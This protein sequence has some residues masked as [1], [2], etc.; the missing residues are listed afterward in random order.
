MSLRTIL[1]TAMSSVFALQGVAQSI[2]REVWYDQSGSLR[3]FADTSLFPN[4]PSWS[5]SWTGPL[6]ITPLNAHGEYYG[7]R[8]RGTL[9]PPAT[10]N[11]RFWIAGDDHAEFW[12]SSSW[13]AR[14][15]NKIASLLHCTSEL[16][17]D[18]HPS[19]RSAPQALQAGVPYHFEI[20]HK[21]HWGYDHVA[22]A[23]AYEPT[24]WALAS[25]GST[26][27]QSS[28]GAG[29][30][31]S[32]AIDGNTNG[33]WWSAATITH[34]AN[35][36]NSW[37]QLDFGQARTINRVVLWNRTD[38]N[39]QSRLSN[40]RV[41]VTDDSGAEVASQTFFPPGSGAM[42]DSMTW[43]LPQSV[44]ARRI[45]VSFLG[46][47]NDGNGYLSL[48]EVQALQAGEHTQRV[49]VPASALQ[50]VIA[51][52]ADANQ[53]SLADAWENQFGLTHGSGNGMAA[54]EYADPDGDLLPNR[55][56]AQLG[57][58]PLVPN[59]ASGR[60]TQERWN[61]LFH[62][63]VDDL[64]ESSAFYQAAETQVLVAPD[65]LKFSG[66][67]FG[68]R[69]RGYI[70]PEQSGY[71]T[72]W[73]SG[74]NSAALWLSTDATRGK[75]AKQL[76]ADVDPQKGAGHGIDSESANL[77]DQFAS[78]QSKAVYLE[79]GKSYYL[80]ILHQNGHA[81]NPHS[82]VA[83]A[84]DGG[85]RTTIPASAVESY[86]KTA[87]DVDDD[88]LPDAWESQHGLDATDNGRIDLAR[89]GE[90]GDFDDD[91]LT[92]RQE[93]L[94]G[95]DPANADTDG[96]GLSDAEE[97]LALSTQALTANAIHDTLVSTISLTQPIAS[98]TGWSSTSGGMVADSFRGEAT[99]A[100]SVPSASH[101]LLRLDMEVMGATYGSESIPVAIKIDGQ[102]VERKLV[103]FGANKRG[104]LQVLSPWLAAGSHQ[105][106]VLIDN[107]LARRS[108]R[109][110]SLKLL[111]PANPAA[112]LA[113]A[114]QVFSHAAT[115]RTSPAFLEGIARDPAAV[116]LQQQ[117]VLPG[118]G[119]GHWYANLPLVNQPQA[120]AYH[121][122]FEQGSETTGSLTWQATNVMDSETLT[123]RQGDA[124]RV[125][126][127]TAD[128][129]MT[130]TLTPPSGPAV[131]LSGSATTVVSF[132]QSG[133]YPVTA[134]L[135]NG[136]SAILTVHVIAPPSSPAPVLDTLEN[137][138]RTWTVTAAPQIVF[139]APA[140][141]CRLALA[142]TA[143]QATLSVAPRQL[144]PMAIAARLF[145]GGPILSLQ[146]LNVIAVSDALQNDL[147]TNATSPV[148]GYKIVN[149]PLTILNLPTGGRVELS[150]FRAGVL[151]LDG[152][153]FRR[154]DPQDVVNG[155]VPLSF[156]FPL[157]M[158][159][160][161]CH[162]VSVYDRNGTLLGTR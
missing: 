8:L 96:D 126:A 158:P 148:P 41:S 20:I 54:S 37:W 156:L 140:D 85:P 27:T 51:D 15:K 52:P 92:N 154:I 139:E 136:A 134:T 127:W 102:T 64:V 82:S 150:I 123:V 144:D 124:L 45:K 116:T 34:T 12:L 91:G 129:A 109:L 88:H 74:R 19:Q 6:K 87:D 106:S 38:G 84:R 66:A 103:R 46:W 5:E 65:A 97:Y 152:T 147:T 36:P 113:Q 67:Y 72:F 3:Q 77:W 122:R 145:E 107:T 57:F 157:G 48:A 78:Q 114:N 43:D 25:H 14:D 22:V 9:V 153:T 128:P 89:Q 90:R 18:A 94:L 86:H 26:A 119:Q 80:E 68:T 81:G 93:Y 146:R 53:N 131:P 160:G 69:T 142:R 112:L 40:F 159:G 99:W 141:L 62:Y 50:P 35:L 138:M 61:G 58:H 111:A 79:A 39:L 130:A 151:F 32:R 76:L 143:S 24:N 135:A 75:Y 108:V 30:L 100:F 56:E 44:S 21:E 28:D 120:Q 110:V 10:G 98:T 55:E 29:G 125:G 117:A 33:H 4:T 16:A 42:G 132:P 63:S 11:W 17:F 71:H 2:Q 23:W 49:V 155:S 101:W 105:V 73:I 104:L 149:T 13:K 137:N 83:W 161:Y 70:K 31:A 162:Y 121:V 1:L 60:W 118:M 47:N 95:T 7:Q 59:R 133:S 115:T